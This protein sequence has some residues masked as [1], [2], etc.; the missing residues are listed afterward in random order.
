M[1]NQTEKAA[2]GLNSYLI[3]HSSEVKGII[4]IY[5]GCKILQ[6]FVPYK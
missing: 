3:F 1:Q 6:G 5:D 4:Y 2:S